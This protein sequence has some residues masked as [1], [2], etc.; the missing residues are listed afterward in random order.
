MLA[1]HPLR[2]RDP[3]S[4]RGEP[5]SPGAPLLLRGAASG[6]PAR[7]WDPQ[8]LV[9]RAGPLPV[10]LTRSPG[11]RLEF[12]RSSPQALRQTRAT[13]AESAAR[14]AGERP[15][16]PRHYVMQQPLAALLP[17]LVDDLRTEEL[18]A[19][20]DPRGAHL[21]FGG[22]AIVTPLHYDPVH[23][24][25]VQLYG[26]KRMLLAAPDELAGLYPADFAGD[27][28]HISRVDPEHPDLDAHPALADVTLWR[29]DL[30]PGDVL[31]LPAFWWHHVRSLSTAVS[32]NLWHAPDLSAC[33]HATGWRL[34]RTIYAVDR[35]RQVGT[36]LADHPGGLLGA[37]K[38][39]L[40]R[41]RPR[42]AA[43]FLAAALHRS[44]APAAVIAA[45]EEGCDRPEEPDEHALGRLLAALHPP[46]TSS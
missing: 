10:T 4:S 42:F 32:V 6:W 37:A 30:E 40:A 15:G 14:I 8:T 24:F 27:C 33:L 17:A 31:Y 2:S 13:L 36:P 39:A 44:G 3:A 11:D 1:V 26:R 34:F 7:A 9:A 45:L 25:Y 28:P 20:V 18:P 43:L 46:G 35:L 38:E 16:G 23:N 41:G 12:D 19:A 5:F 22:P 29:A 21:W